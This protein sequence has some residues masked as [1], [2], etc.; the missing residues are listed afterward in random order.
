MEALDDPDD[1]VR[2][3]AVAALA[4]LGDT[5]AVQVLIEKLASDPAVQAAAATA[6]GS[7]GDPAAVAPLIDRLGDRA[8]VRVAA[9]KA[10]AQLEQP[11]WSEWIKGEIFDYIRL[12]ECRDPRI[13]P[14]LEKLRSGTLI[15]AGN[16][17]MGCCHRSLPVRGS[18]KRHI[19][20][21]AKAPA[22]FLVETGDCRAAEPLLCFWLFARDWAKEEGSQDSSFWSMEASR[23]LVAYAASWSHHPEAELPQ[24]WVTVPITARASHQFEDFPREVV[25][26]SIELPLPEDSLAAMAEQ[27]AAVLGNDGFR[28]LHLGMR[29]I[30]SI[31]SDSARAALTL[32]RS[33]FH[34]A[35]KSISHGA[36]TEPLK[37]GLVRA[38]GA[39]IQELRRLG[40]TLNASDA[41]R[42]AAAAAGGDAPAGEL[43]AAALQKVGKDGVVLV[44][45]WKCPETTLKWTDS[46]PV[47]CG[48]ASLG[49]LT[50]T[51]QT[52]CVL[53]SVCVLVCEG[54]VGSNWKTLI[55]LVEA[56]GRRGACLL[57]AAEQVEGE[58]IRFLLNNHRRNIVRSCALAA[59]GEGGARIRDEIATLTG[60]LKQ[61]DADLD[62]LKPE[63][64]GYA[65]RI[66][67]DQRTTR[68]IGG[69]GSQDHAALAEAGV[70]AARIL[71]GGASDAERRDKKARIERAVAAVRMALTEG[72]VS[73]IGGALAHAS[74][75]LVSLEASGDEMV[76]V[77]I[78]RLACENLAGEGA[79]PV[80]AIRLALET[81][82]SASVLY[83]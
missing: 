31:S 82:G 9:A 70:P 34:Q 42:L 39:V 79:E 40:T 50:D 37:C 51:E 7:L 74:Q 48:C 32:T 56:A 47:P 5:R 57:L 59:P 41:S 21:D 33:I 23:A 83:W 54:K 60:C 12:A 78:V 62:H 4:Q 76:G 52:Q 6:L 27:L 63:E 25:N 16:S 20:Y 3:A 15:H 24:G 44:D 77:Q 26:A 19:D 66:V 38:I 64:L 81:A 1:G 58:A 68:I 18:R 55:P 8:E 72:I 80:R 46:V 49:F 75:A 29:E 45:E 35:A 13:G 2:K 65:R 14:A 53:D 43:A 28:T 30:G 61:A 11:Q 71:V 67:V 17:L 69:E 10:L 22:K 36:P 73:S